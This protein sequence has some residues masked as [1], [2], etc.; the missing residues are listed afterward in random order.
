ML[1]KEVQTSEKKLFQT[2][3]K[4]GQSHNRDQKQMQGENTPTTGLDES[5]S[6]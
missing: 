4:R 5:T 6:Y 1:E 3:T 2:C